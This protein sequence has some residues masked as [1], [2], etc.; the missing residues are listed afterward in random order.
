MAMAIA[1]GAGVGIWR[2]REHSSQKL[3]PAVR[4]G[5]RTDL[6]LSLTH[7]YSLPAPPNPNA[8]VTR[9]SQ[10][11]LNDTSLA[12]LSLANGDW[13][14]FF[15]DN[16]GLIRRLIRTASNSRWSTSADQN[17]SLSSNPKINTP[18]TANINDF[19]EVLTK[20]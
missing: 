5:I 18:L 19:S 14:Q 16:N 4:C 2:H 6:S 11:I 13:H 10:I 20:F 7:I 17:L 9:A 1:V 15:Q 12:A 3:S 8:N